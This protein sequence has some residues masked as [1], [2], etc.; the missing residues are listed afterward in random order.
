[1]ISNRR[2][3][4]NDH[5]CF[6][7]MDCQS[8]V[9]ADSS[10]SGAPPTVHGS[11]A[12]VVGDGPF[13]T[14]DSYLLQCESGEGFNQAEIFSP[15]LAPVIGLNDFCLDA[16]VKCELLTDLADD[17]PTEPYIKLSSLAVV[18]PAATVQFAFK[19][20]APEAQSLTLLTEADVLGAVT[21]GALG[22]PDE[23]WRH[24]LIA[25]RVGV[26]YG[27]IDGVLLGS[28]AN[29]VDYAGW[30]YIDIVVDNYAPD[31]GMYVDQVRLSIGNSRWVGQP[32]ISVPNRRYGGYEAPH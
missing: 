29:V 2:G 10:R 5:Q 28:H 18:I 7:C 22:H 20:N 8:A 4:G 24:V 3:Y 25:R 30:P 1:M 13:A 11:V 19:T 17:G 12:R 23:V 16:W 6:W 14:G 15:E 27:Y 21:V 9:P 32:K 26:V 31:V